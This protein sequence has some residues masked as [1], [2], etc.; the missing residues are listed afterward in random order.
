MH[1]QCL[2]CNYYQYFHIFNL[3]SYIFIQV[4]AEQGNVPNIIIAVSLVLVFKILYLYFSK[5][6]FVVSHSKKYF[7]ATTIQNW[8]VMTLLKNKEIKRK[9]SIV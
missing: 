6:D 4:F 7:L 9:G 1:P 2:E 8:Q 3:S 5:M